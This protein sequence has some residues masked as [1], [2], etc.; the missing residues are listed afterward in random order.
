MS[1]RFNYINCFIQALLSNFYKS[2]IMRLCFPN[3]E[4]FRCIT[5]P[6]ISYYRDIYIKDITIFEYFFFRG[7]AVTDNLINA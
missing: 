1:T 6:S 2:F 7:Y 5:M 4:H 3:H